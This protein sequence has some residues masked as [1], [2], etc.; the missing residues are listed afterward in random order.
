[1]SDG[2]PPVPL[3][4]DIQI[5]AGSD[6]DRAISGDNDGVVGAQSRQRGRGA[7]RRV[8]AASVTGPV[9]VGAALGVIAVA[10]SI[11]RSTV[12]GVSA[13]HALVL[14]VVA[15]AAAL[16]SALGTDPAP[17]A[18]G[19]AAAVVSLTLFHTLTVAAALAQLI[20]LHRLARDG[21]PRTRDQAIAVCLPVAFLVLVFA[22][23]VPSGSE[24]GVL[25]MLLAALAPA[26]ALAGVTRQA[27]GEALRQNAAR[28]AIAG[29]LL[30]H[31]ARGERARIARELHDVVAHHISMIAVQAEAARMTTPDLSPRGAQRLAAI[32]DTARAALT[33]MRRLLGVLREDARTVA[34]DLQPQPPS[35]SSTNCST[36][37]VTRAGRR[38]A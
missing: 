6:A 28:Q 22:R 30:E 19:V 33:E 36:R 15:L 20:V 2:G 7:P 23:P 16:P 34:A 35:I 31:A 26:A 12:T 38:P 18:A 5:A 4:S 14:C 21:I 29:D 8:T 17:A 13:Q 37:H 24:A 27:R 10:E 3:R 11:V 9:A 1:M 32:G 25:T